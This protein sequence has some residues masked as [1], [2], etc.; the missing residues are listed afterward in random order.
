M[1]S[2]DADATALVVRSGELQEAL[3]ELSEAIARLTGDRATAKAAFA[4][5]DDGPD[6]AIAAADAEQ[7]RAEMAVQAEAYVR[8]RAE[9]ALLRWTISR[10]RAQRQTPLLKRASD[11]FSKLTLGRY[12]EL[13]VDVESDKARLAGLAHDQSVVPVEVMSEG[14]VD[15]LFMALRIAAVEDAV[16][17][18]AVLPFIADDLFINYDDRRAR[19]GFQVLAE[20]AQT[21][22]VLFFT[23]HQHLVTVAEEAL[24]P[25]NVSKCELA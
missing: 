17:A 1:E 9:A 23:H 3:A 21:T 4:Q 10:Y 20:L 2:V 16:R 25:L 12:M 7:A 13:L 22:Q 24:A 11:I 15:Q 19:A 6:A 5:L 14:T 8:K 18:G